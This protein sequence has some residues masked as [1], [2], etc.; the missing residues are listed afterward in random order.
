MYV[1]LWMAVAWQR[2]DFISRQKDIY[3]QYDKSGA[4]NQ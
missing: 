2:R 1:F 4:T 3:W